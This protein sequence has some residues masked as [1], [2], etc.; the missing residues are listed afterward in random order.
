MII[1]PFVEDFIGASRLAIDLVVAVPKA[2][3][4]VTSDFVNNRPRGFS[5]RE[6]RIGST[7]IRNQGES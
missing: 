6:L 7:R 2:I 4:A 1:E 3:A 5:D